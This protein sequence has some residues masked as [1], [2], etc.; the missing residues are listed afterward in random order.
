MKKKIS[1][2]AISGL[3]KKISGAHL[4]LERHQNVTGNILQYGTFKF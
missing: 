4:C 3:E 2:L 1:G